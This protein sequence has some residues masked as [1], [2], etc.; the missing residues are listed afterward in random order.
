MSS[1]SITV[2]S[3]FRPS[4]AQRRLL[5]C[6]HSNPGV[7]T[8][9]ALC[10]AAGV[11]RT[12]YYRWCQDPAFRLWFADAWAACLFLD[13]AR[14][15][16]ICRLRD[17]PNEAPFDESG[18]VRM[19]NCRQA[20]ARVNPDHFAPAT[21]APSSKIDPGAGFQGAPAEFPPIPQCLPAL[22]PKNGT[23]RRSWAVATHASPR[24]PRL[25]RS[26]K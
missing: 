26:K 24:R 1:H 8:A 5:H 25:G 10:A 12:T 11:S 16:N 13:G 19:R 7:K 18:L 21:A 17:T 6:I 2:A 3:P 4:P 20:V 14:L 9:L 15:I 23:N 22:T